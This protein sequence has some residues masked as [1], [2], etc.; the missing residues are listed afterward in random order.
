MPFRSH[1]EAVVIE[2]DRQVCF[3]LSEPAP[4]ASPRPV[5][6]LT[7][8]HAEALAEL[9]QIFACGEESAAIAFAGLA[10]SPVN[11]A[12]RGALTSIARE[13]LTHEGLLRGM[14][15]ALP[16]PP[17]DRELRRALVHFYHGIADADVGRHFAAIAS[18]DSA[19]CLI[20]SAFLRAGSVVARELTVSTIF[21]RIHRDEA[22]HVRVSRHIASEFLRK[23]LRGAVAERNR[24]GLVGVLVRR[25]AAFE[26]LG[27]DAERLFA[28]LRRV[29]DGLVQ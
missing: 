14:R 13:E 11:E 3:R 15:G 20:L 21:R 5:L 6:R 18:L 12:A 7:D 4:I 9:L 29:P 17:G 25:G 24:V 10:H 2:L 23:E 16:E 26:R 1:R 22:K 28:R 8:A 27:I 19:V